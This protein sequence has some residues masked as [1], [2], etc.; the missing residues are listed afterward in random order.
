M[1]MVNAVVDRTTELEE[2]ALEWAAKINGKSPTATRMLKFAMNLTDDGLVGQQVFAGEATRLAYMTDEAAGGARR[3]PREARAGLVRLPVPL[4]MREPL[5]EAARPRTLPAAVAPVLVG[6][7]AAARPPAGGSPCSTRPPAPHGL[8]RWSSR[9]RCR[10]RSTTP[11][12]GSTG[13][14]ASTRTPGPGPAGRSPAA[15][16][17]RAMRAGDGRRAGG[18]RRSRAGARVAGRAGSC[19]SSVRRRSRHARLQRRPQRPYA[20]AGLGEVFVFVFFGLVATVGSAYVQDEALTA[21]RRARRRRRWVRSPPRCWWSTTCATSRPTRRRQAHAGGA[22]RGGRTRGS[23][24]VPRGGAYLLLVPPVAVVPGVLAGAAAAARD[25][26]LAWKGDRAGP[27]RPLGPRLVEALEHTARGQLLFAVLLPSASSLGRRPRH[28]GLAERRTRGPSLGPSAS[29][30][31]TLPRR[32]RTHRGAAARP[33]RVGRVLAVPRVRPAYASR[34][35]AAAREAATDAVPH[36]VRDR[37]PVNTT[38]PAVDPATPTTSSAASGCRDREGQ[39]RRDRSGPR[40]RRRARR[41]GPRRPRPDGASAST[42]TVPGTSR[43][44]CSRSR[45][46]TPPPVAS[47]TSSSPAAPSTSSARSAAGSR[48]RSPP[49]SRCARPRTRCGSP[50][51]MPPTSS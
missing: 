42:R 3:L 7:A 13:S 48:C 18:R 43:P 45:G 15:W 29:H 8:L 11:T 26:S 12:T 32:H 5:V 17:P 39:G 30:A 35:L 28:D 25:A 41:R 10:S 9:S 19:C 33:G 6:T 31:P 46:S 24:S 27:P 38:V 14:R 36:P 21:G 40:R 34:W 16:S 23:T 50:G 2:V 47:S 4:L 1:G 37:V 51:S 20:S 44:P 22:A 49:T